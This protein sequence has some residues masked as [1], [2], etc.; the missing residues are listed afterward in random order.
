MVFFPECFD[1]VG[2]SKDETIGMA[3]PENGAYLD[4]FRELAKSAG[5]WLSLGGFH[6]KVSSFLIVINGIK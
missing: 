5:L 1:Y 4:K 6:N 3:F 2:R